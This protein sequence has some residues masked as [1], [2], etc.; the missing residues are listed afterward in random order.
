MEPHYHGETMTW[1]RYLRFWGPDVDADID[2]ELRFHLE[3][4]VGDYVAAGYSPVEARRLA[5]E[6]FGDLPSVQGTLRRH[7]IRKLQQQ[8]RAETMDELMNDIRYGARKLLQAPGFTMAVV[9][10]L[11]LGIGANTAIYSAVDA[12]FFRPLPFAN[13]ER[14]VTLTGIE[15]PMNLAGSGIPPHPKAAA[16]VSDYEKLDVFE[17]FAVHAVGG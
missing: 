17:S 8:R 9:A 14:L 11:A 1:R 5:T 6:R 15:L 13:P 12:A 3:S 4:R 10:V 16:D 7:D 2:D